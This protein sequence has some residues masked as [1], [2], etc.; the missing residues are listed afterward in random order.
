MGIDISP[1]ARAVITAAAMSIA[2]GSS[3]AWAQDLNP[4]VSCLNGSV[5]E[6]SYTEFASNYRKS[7][8]D[9][10]SAVRI[11]AEDA[12]LELKVTD[13][14]GNTVCEETAN[15]KARC[16]FTIPV[17]YAGVFVM[18]V[19]NL[20]ATGGPRNFRLCAE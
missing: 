19:D 20:D 5:S 13:L 15:S 12:P 3:G 10:R 16:K 6:A 7:I 4:G 2:A 17:D 11:R 1:K 8:W 14:Y 18:R 9:S